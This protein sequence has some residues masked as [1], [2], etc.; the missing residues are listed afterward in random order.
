MR[1]DRCHKKVVNTI[2]TSI[3]NYAM[4]TF[5]EFIDD[6]EVN[7]VLVVIGG[8]PKTLCYDCYVVVCDKMREVINELS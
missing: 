2:T 1:C 6:G 3:P 8:S 5:P 7:E 4:E